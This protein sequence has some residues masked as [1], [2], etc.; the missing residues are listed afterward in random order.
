M[1]LL[2]CP[3]LHLPPHILNQ[4]WERSD[5]EPPD[6]PS[7]QLGRSPTSASSLQGVEGSPVE[8][9]VRKDDLCSQPSPSTP[10]YVWSKVISK[11]G[12][13]TG[14]R[15][16]Y[17]LVMLMGDCFVRNFQVQDNHSRTIPTNL[18]ITSSFRSVSV[19]IVWRCEGNNL[20]NC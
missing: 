16:R 11:S 15:D 2:T 19:Q 7:C 5:H 10:G 20:E 3:T 18:G 14:S 8:E 1:N 6:P 13:R 12:K 9:S 4:L 17:C